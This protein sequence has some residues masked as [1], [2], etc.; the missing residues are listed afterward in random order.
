ML[1]DN[2]TVTGSWV[3]LNASNL[4][5]AYDKYSR[6]INNVT[7]SMPHAGVF[8]AA[9]DAKNG[10]LQPEDLAGVGEYSVRASVVSPTVN[11]LCVNMNST[12]LSPLIYTEWP[13]AKTNTSDIPDQ[14]IPWSGYQNDIQLEPGQSWLNK[15]VVD[16]IFEWGATY[17]RQ[18]P[19]FPMVGIRFPFCWNLELTIQ[20]PIDYN[21]LTNI[22]VVNSDS[23]YLLIKSFSIPDYTVC[24]VR[25]F[26]SPACSTQ[27]NVSGTSQGSLQSHCEDPRDPDAYD[28]S[29]E[30]A[31]VIK[32]PDWRSVGQDWALAVALDS[33]VSS[34]NSSTARLLSQFVYNYP[35]WGTRQL[36][37]LLPSISEVLAVMAGNTLLL[38]TMDSTYY[39]FWNYTANELDPGVYLNFNASL[40]SQQYTSGALQR[41]QGIFYI[42]LILV[43]A[44][45]VFCLVYFFLRSG[46]V[47]DYTEPAN[48][49]AIAVNSPPSE[50]LSGSCGAGP[51]RRQLN[52]PFHV[53]QEEGSN[54]FF[55]KEGDETGGGEFELRRRRSDRQD[56]KSM[57]S[58]SKLSSK[59]RS[60]L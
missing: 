35:G 59:R 14:K 57:T 26:I 39:H 30:G 2:T 12:E 58:Y 46:L 55:I 24:Q 48:L 20:F 36:S 16:D 50:R 29:V 21:S 45:N 7:M 56:L 37:P 3:Q 27:Y 4:T 43:F 38:G 60:F 17:A 47:T 44:T 40:A 18:P 22:T 6:I 28:K 53:R 25:S 10:I 23:I 49:F 34:S 52:V 32:T 19:V 9:H 54:H 42:V 5:A 31:P 15:T 11:V 41:W 13:H 33:G 8:S 51:E 1:F